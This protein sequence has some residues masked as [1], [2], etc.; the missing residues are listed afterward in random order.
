MRR[1]EGGALQRRDERLELDY[2]R[3]G[4]RDVVLQKGGEGLAHVRFL[5][6][7]L[8]VFPRR[9]RQIGE[10]TVDDGSR[11]IDAE[12]ELRCGSM[13]VEEGEVA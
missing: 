3:L 12:A 1:E 9:Q 8:E 10:L 2:E 6:E 5:L 4:E 13:L 11:G 7:G